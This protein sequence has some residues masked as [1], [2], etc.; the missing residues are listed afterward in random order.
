[1][2]YKEVTDWALEYD[3]NLLATDERFEN[4]LVILFVDGTF[5][6]RT[7][8]FAMISDGH[9]V[10]FGEHQKPEVHEFSDIIY[11]GAVKLNYPPREDS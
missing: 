10:V 8:S 1:M 4:S 7:N 5:Q 11:W 6:N 9:V 3:K 2:K